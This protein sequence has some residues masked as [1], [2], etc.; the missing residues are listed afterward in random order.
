MKHVFII[1]F[2]LYN[3]NIV[4]CQDFSLVQKLNSVSEA[5]EKVYGFSGTVKVVIDHN[6]TFEKSYGFAN[7]SFEIKNTPKT[8][9]SINSISKTFT[10]TAVLVLVEHGRIDIKA[11]VKRYIPGLKASWADSI[12]V[13]HL[14]THTSG[15]PRESGVQ[16]HHELTFQE[17][18]E[19]VEKQSLLFTP[20][21]R[22]EYSNAGIIL[23]GAIIENMSGMSYREFIVENIIQPLNLSNT[24]Y[25]NGRNVISNLAV[26][27]RITSNGLEFTQRSKHYGDNAGGGLYSTPSDLFRFVEG[28]ENYSI[29]SKKYVDMMFQSHVKSGDSDFEGYAWSIK[30]FGDEKLYFAAGSG[31]GTKSVIIRMPE[32][33]N[34]I[35]ITSNW[36]N[37]PILQLLSD[38]YLTIKNKDVALPSEDELATPAFYKSQIGTYIFNKEELTKHL[39]I[40]RAKII[41]Q[42]VNGRLFLDDE[43][44]R[45]NGKYLTLTYTDE[46]KIEFK[47]DKM[48][49][50]MN[51]NIIEGIKQYR[52]TYKR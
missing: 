20:G 35:G 21:E 26:P 16:P 38:L 49:I 10:A 32:S 18:V 9:F 34:F 7:R 6:D 17:Q 31:Y 39:G 47:G 40:K 52:K 41:L 13:H 51:D 50:N 48:I 1:T 22:Y 28:L 2:L 24:G 19:L 30:Y 12:T 3:L 37:T 8:R 23:L 42:E 15:L 14:L 27:Y 5:Y 29:L 36:G 43:L 33:G 25:Y 44:L 45:D 4:F 11:P 46:L